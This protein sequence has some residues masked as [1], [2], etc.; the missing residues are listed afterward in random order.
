MIWQ[1]HE[2]EDKPNW[3]RYA[4]TYYGQYIPL[5]GNRLK[6]PVDNGKRHLPVVPKAQH[7]HHTRQC[8]RYALEARPPPRSSSPCH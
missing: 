6:T 5:L 7:I 3:D 1:A 2:N 8:G 4:K